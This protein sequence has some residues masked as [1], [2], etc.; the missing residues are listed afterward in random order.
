MERRRG[1]PR[2]GRGAPED[3]RELFMYQIEVD[4]VKSVTFD[5]SMVRDLLG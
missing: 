5:A 1:G 2:I 3:R 4:H